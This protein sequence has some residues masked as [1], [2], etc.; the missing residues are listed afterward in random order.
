MRE[1]KFRAWDTV[2]NKMINDLQ[3]RCGLS[4][5]LKCVNHIIMQYTGL[6]DNNGKEIWESDIALFCKFDLRLIGLIKQAEDGRWLVYADEGNF[7]VAAAHLAELEVI[8]NIHDN[9][10]LWETKP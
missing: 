6:K 4:S 2:E 1:I 3:D 5:D 9:P 8:G 7:L 10:E